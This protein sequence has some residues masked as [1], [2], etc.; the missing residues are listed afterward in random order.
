MQ[1]I[2]SVLF[3]AP[4]FS[5]APDIPSWLALVRE[6]NQLQSERRVRVAVVDPFKRRIDFVFLK[7]ACVCEQLDPE[8]GTGIRRVNVHA[9]HQDILTAAGLT[10]RICFGSVGV[11]EDLSTG[12]YIACIVEKVDTEICKEPGF[13][14]WGRPFVG[15]GL[16]VRGVEVASPG[17]KLHLFDKWEDVRDEDCA[18][19]VWL[20]TKAAVTARLEYA[21]RVHSE[22]DELIREHGPTTV[23]GT[24]TMV[25]TKKKATCWGCGQ[26][27]SARHHCGR[28]KIAYYCTEECQRRH[29]PEHRHTCQADDES[30]L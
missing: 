5:F 21:A 16:I 11:A 19:I 26:Q 10:D 27:E 9:S 13:M 30:G 24:I 2:S 20:G 12:A 1:P 17:P 28:C 6:N 8:L 29:W 15:R 7:T 25:H 23:L 22:A 4:K 18:N 14:V 3:G